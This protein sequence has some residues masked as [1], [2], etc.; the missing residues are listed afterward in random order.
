ML[1][2]LETIAHLLSPEIVFFTDS[3]LGLYLQSFAKIVEA[4]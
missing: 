3:G 2:P 4:L 1:L